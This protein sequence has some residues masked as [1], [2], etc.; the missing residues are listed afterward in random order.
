MTKKFTHIN[1]QDNPHM[2]SVSDK[3]VTDRMARAEAIVEVS[4]EVLSHFVEGELKTK[5]GP[6]FQTA[7]IAGIQGAKKTGDLIPLCHPIGMD[8]C[9]VTI[10]VVDHLIRIECTARVRAKTG[11]EMEAL[12]GATIAALTIYDMCKSFGHE[13]VIK[14][15]RLMEKRGGKKDFLRE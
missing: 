15:I 13:I 8:H 12:T 7:I 9:Q 11:I 14:K 5:K 1:D 6:V 4:E 10:E 2:V 3:S